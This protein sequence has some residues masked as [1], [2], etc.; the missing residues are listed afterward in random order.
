M[1]FLLDVSFSYTLN[2]IGLYY[3]IQIWVYS[4]LNAGVLTNLLHYITLHT[5][6]KSSRILLL[7]YSST[8]EMHFYISVNGNLLNSVTSGAVV[9]KFCC[10][11][12]SAMSATLTRFFVVL[13]C[14]CWRS[15]LK[16]DCKLWTAM[17]RAQCCRS[18]GVIS[19]WYCAMV[20]V[21]VSLN[22]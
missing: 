14:R 22:V 12:V 20:N 8:F 18:I 13:S 2:H 9:L 6:L 5:V 15:V 1:P 19:I 3:M 21:V 7:S 11:S 10:F 16:C 17:F 4:L